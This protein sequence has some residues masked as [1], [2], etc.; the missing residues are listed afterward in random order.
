MNISPFFHLLYFKII[1]I[2]RNLSDLQV[3]QLV[4]K[5]KM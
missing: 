2:E 3:A 5:M 4:N 1:S